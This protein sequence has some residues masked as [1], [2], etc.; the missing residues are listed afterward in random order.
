MEYKEPIQQDVLNSM[1]IRNPE[2][3]SNG[4]IFCEINHPEF[5]WIPFHASKDDVEEHGRV[6][7]ERIQKEFDDIPQMVEEPEI[8]LGPTLEELVKQIAERLD[9]LEKK[10]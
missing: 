1:P 2:R 3:L 9:A 5:G 7:F 8:P 6:L 4:M 10:I